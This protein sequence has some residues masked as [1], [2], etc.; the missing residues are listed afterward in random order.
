LQAGS[1]LSTDGMKKSSTHQEK[2]ERT[3]IELLSPHLIMETEDQKEFK[4][5]VQ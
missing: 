2:L 3:N 4:L 5:K 1:R